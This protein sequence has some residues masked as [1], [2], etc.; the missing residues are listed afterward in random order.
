ME[1][2][3]PTAFVTLREKI[4]YLL[5]H[6]GP[7]TRMQ[8][9]IDGYKTPSVY[10]TAWKLVADG[11]VVDSKGYLTLSSA[12][13]KLLKE[14][15]NK[16][17]LDIS[18]AMVLSAFGSEPM[19]VRDVLVV[20]NIEDSE[21]NINTVRTRLQLLFRRDELAKCGKKINR[22]ILY[23]TCLEKADDEAFS[24]GEQLAALRASWDKKIAMSVLFQTALP[25]TLSAF[26]APKP[27]STRI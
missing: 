17:R 8:I 21:S 12:G 22:S 26:S 14:I 7:I 20:L 24:V 10:P 5:H 23:T 25:G 15:T 3:Y 9:K 13:L 11:R 18:T 2:N 1:I 19:T 27:W 16:D 6:E 4:I